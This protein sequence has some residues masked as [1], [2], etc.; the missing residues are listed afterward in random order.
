MKSPT[1]EALGDHS[2]TLQVDYD[3]AVISYEA[4]LDVFWD[5]HD[6]TLPAWSRQYMTAIFTHTDEQ[7]RLA[8]ASKAREEA[9]IKGRIVTAILPL[10]E[11]TRAEGYH[12]KYRLRWERDILRELTA[13]YPREKDFVDSTAAA[14]INGYLDG[15]GTPAELEEDLPGFGLSPQAAKQLKTLVSKR[16]GRSGCRLP[17][18]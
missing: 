9:R 2:E 7:R 16:K 14:R 13:I 6:P 10:G 4:L 11:F 15:Y 5:S 17:R 18:L 8:E 12:Q 1:Y 3:P